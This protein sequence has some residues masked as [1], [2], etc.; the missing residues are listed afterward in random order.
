VANPPNDQIYDFK[1][2]FESNVSSRANQINEGGDGALAS[3]GND[4]ELLKNDSQREALSLEN[5]M[6]ANTVLASS[7]HVLGMVV[8]TGIESRAQMNSRDSQTKVGKLDLE[9]NLLSKYLFVAMLILSF[10]I[11]AL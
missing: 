5:T 7:G 6:W 8:F 10:C 11:V 1:G 2:Y 3:P 4:A 9:I